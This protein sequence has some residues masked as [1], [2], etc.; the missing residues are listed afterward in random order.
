MKTVDLFKIAVLPILFFS[1]C[2]SENSSFVT[3]DR[4]YTR[5]T[6]TYETRSDQTTARARFRFGNIYGTLL[7]LEA[8]SSISLNDEALSFKPLFSYYEKII[9]GKVA[10]GTFSWITLDSVELLNTITLDEIGF[11][12]DFTEISRDSS[13][14]LKWVGNPLEQYEYVTLTLSGDFED[15]SATIYVSEVGR[16]WLTIPMAK[17]QNLPADQVSKFRL[18]FGNSPPLSQSTSSGGLIIGKYRVSKDIMIR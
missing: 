14:T 5:Y 10:E 17:L 16:T 3:Q 4:I 11:P 13:Y 15:E 9:P 6:L 18:E 7:E 12:D 2:E 1:A 8:P